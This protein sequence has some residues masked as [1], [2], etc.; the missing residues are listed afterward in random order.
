MSE[1]PPELTTELTLD[2]EAT[3]D[4]LRIKRLRSRFPIL[5]HS[6]L[7]LTGRE[8]TLAI[9]CPPESLL[10]VLDKVVDLRLQSFYVAAAK[11][12]R[13]Y[14]GNELIYESPTLPRVEIATSQ[15]ETDKLGKKPKGVHSM[16]TAAVQE[17]P[18]ETKS[19]NES[20]A[21]TLPE[22]EDLTTLAEKTGQPAAAIA[23]Q[24]HAAGYPAGLNRR[25]QNYEASVEGIRQW[26]NE[27][28]Q[29]DI[30]SYKR[31]REAE[32]MG[33]TPYNGLVPTQEA[34]T[35][36]QPKKVRTRRAKKTDSPQQTSGKVRFKSFQKANSRNGTLGKFL[37]AQKWDDAKRIEI[38][39][40]I[41][42]LPPE[43]PA[44]GEE[45]SF[46]E[47]CVQYVLK[48][49]SSKPTPAMRREFIATAKEMQGQTATT[50]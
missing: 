23:Q 41:S 28:L 13:I 43:A 32:L 6:N 15:A 40:Q 12:V 37:A 26:V 46:A 19:V 33:I 39:E 21:V 36:T 22:L 20:V 9:V 44:E 5:K 14:G 7:M 1:S 2:D 18:T 42:Q 16:T 48:N 29:Q 24:I 45:M 4:V 47:H 38:L 11:Q 25:S 8:R 35:T 10:K 17:R 30:E 27:F 34:L 31:Q 3:L 50:V 49:Y